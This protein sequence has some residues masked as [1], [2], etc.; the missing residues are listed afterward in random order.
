MRDA[1]Q[2][3]FVKKIF[4][5]GDKRTLKLKCYLT[6]NVYNATPKNTD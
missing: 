5:Y 6:T 4:D 2:T 3:T 1:L